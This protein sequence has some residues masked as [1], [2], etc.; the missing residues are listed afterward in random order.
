[1]FKDKK[2]QFLKYLD[3]TIQ[4]ADKEEKE[5]LLDERK[6][7]A[8]HVKVK[9]NI[10]NV[11]KTTFQAVLKNRTEEEFIALYINKMNTI[12]ANWKTSYENAKA[13]NDTEKMLI[14]EI[15]LQ[16]LNEI[17]TKFFEI[18]E[19]ADDRDKCNKTI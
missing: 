15:K 13:H 10:Y 19:D 11:F 18:W 14:E 4:A 1:M 8:Q 9:T 16:T 12:P 6:D 3:D 2:V 5:L 7:D 17:R